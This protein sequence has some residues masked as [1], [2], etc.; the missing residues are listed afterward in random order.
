M[1]YRLTALALFFPLT[2]ISCT[3]VEENKKAPVDPTKTFYLRLGG[4][5]TTLH[6]IRAIDTYASLVQSYV[7]ESLA[8][9]N[10]NNYK[11]KA[12]LAR[13]WKVS[14]NKLSYTFYLRKKALWHD[15]K[16]VTAHDVLFSFNAVRNLRYGGA[17][18][19][20]YIE[21][22]SEAKVIDAHTIRFFA[23]KK[24]YET[25]EKLAIVLPIIPRHIYENKF[26]GLS[27]TLTGSGPYTLYE[28][29]RN[30]HIVLKKNP[31]WWG[32]QAPEYKGEHNF[33]FIFFRV[34]QEDHDALLRMAGGQL[35]FIKLRPEDFYK[36]TND[37]PWGKSIFKE[38]VQNRSAKGYRFI[39]WN[40]RKPLFKNKKIRKALGLLINRPLMN[41]K[42]TNK[43][44][45]LARGPVH[46]TSDYADPSIK[47]LPFSPKKALALLKEEGWAD[48]DKNGILDKIEN[49]VKTDFQF[50]LI[51]PR[52]EYEKYLTIYQED[53]KKQ[54][55]IMSLKLVDW[56]SF[57]TLLNEGRFDAVTLSWSG[58][59]IEW[60]PKQIWHS[61]SIK[62]N[63][64]NFIA[65]KNPEVDRLIEKADSELNR[66][67]RIKILRKAFRIIVSDHPY[68]F[69]FTPKY[70]FYGHSGRI[71][72]DR[73]TY[74]YGIGTEYWRFKK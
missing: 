55:I 72:I 73:P 54:G 43:A 36:K 21:N 45:Y 28:F 26:K 30:K 63:G 10:I 22:I 14:R 52:K 37:P 44:F 40:L 59:G 65:Y 39:G 17:R 57:T 34:I 25:L 49:G 2:M 46:P 16:P 11:L 4:Q 53:L 38:K 18:Y 24:Q 67:R 61:A 12:E 1:F 60:H 8:T 32:W 58:G 51:F 47:P 19:A 33:D 7:I 56:T 15:S 69:M 35:D 41:E 6:P 3:C 66:K 68:S 71:K 23:K 70:E 64:S 27:R 50:T 13:S 74:E 42:F 29:K 31:N 9:R 5:P 48:S 20:S 62:S